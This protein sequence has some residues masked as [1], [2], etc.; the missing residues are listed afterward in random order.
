MSDTLTLED[1]LALVAKDRKPSKYHNRKTQAYGIWFDSQIEANRYKSLKLMEAAVEIC[2]LEV[3]PGFLLL[4]GFKDKWGHRHRPVK[5]VG[6]FRYWSLKENH[7][8]VE[9]T[10]G[11]ETPVFKL[12]KKLFAR[13]YPD[14][15]L[16]IVRMS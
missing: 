7:W 8:V 13:E 11:F 16:R 3:Q 4:P 12:K 9:D 15:E 1:Y 6:D 10:K 14:I 2:E 5:Y